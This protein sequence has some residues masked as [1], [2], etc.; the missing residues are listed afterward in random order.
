MIKYVG[1]NDHKVD[2]FEGQYHVKN[3][4]SYN[5]YVIIDDK[6]AIMD[7]VDVHFTKD[8]LNNVHNALDGRLPDYLVVLHM[9]P[10]HSASL[11]S[12][13]K[14][15]PNITV[16]GNVK[17]FPM[18]EQFFPNLKINHKLVVKEGDILELGKHS[19]KFVFAPMIHWPEVMLAYETS[20]KSLFSADAFGKF[21]ALDVEEDWKEEARRYYIGIVGKYGLPVQNL[22]KKIVGIE[23]NTIYPLHGP[24]LKEN[25]G[26][27]LDLYNTWSSYAPEEEGICIAYASIYGNTRKAVEELAS[28]LTCKVELF[29]LAR[30]DMAQAISKAFQ[31]SKLVIASPTYNNG[32]LP[33]VEAFLHGL[34]ERSYQ[35]RTVGIIENGSWA[36]TARKYIEQYFANSKNITILEESVTIKSSLDETS[37]SQI[38]NLAQKLKS[39]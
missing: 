12:L 18:I 4:M 11:Q 31:Y 3:G 17:T 32:V 15:Y 8:W 14:E 33:P 16:I 38:E 35:N 13:L 1:V 6:I 25:L 28:K 36:P 27:Y 2:L 23:I 5:S 30:C 26:Y 22:F 9:E 29:D 7:T 37:K 34:V 10:D 24:V 20:T 39:I 19:L 21:G